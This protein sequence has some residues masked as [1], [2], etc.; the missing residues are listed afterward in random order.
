MIKKPRRSLLALSCAAVIAAPFGPA[1]AI[2]AVQSTHDSPSGGAP[3]EPN[4]G[5]ICDVAASYANTDSL[6]ELVFTRAFGVLTK[7]GTEDL[8]VEY[9]GTAH[10]PELVAYKAGTTD[11]APNGG[12]LLPPGAENR[13]GGDH[14]GLFEYQHETYIIYFRDITHPVSMIAV[15]P[16]A[17]VDS[18]RFTV[19][20]AE[21]IPKTAIEPALCR[22]IITERKSLAFVDFATRAP[23]TG[24][25]FF[26]PPTGGTVGSIATLDAFNDGHPVNAAEI[27]WGSTARAGCDTEYYDLVDGNREKL[28][29]G[30]KHDL[31]IKLQKGADRM[32][33]SKVLFFSYR[34]KVYA[35]TTNNS[36]DR[37]H[38]VTRIEK[39]QVLDVCDFSFNT[40]VSAMQ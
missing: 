29:T 23:I 30:S 27:R 26:D 33:G 14:L 37:V 36:D 32:C 5:T 9:Q 10:V 28:E 24:Q 17:K 38:T 40:T 35:E 4:L 22:D 12:P 11:P 39:G 6:D 8:S 20:T 1:S 19:R 13:W 25:M 2:H 18:C 3:P 34:G 7:D 15:T 16:G 31:F 21:L